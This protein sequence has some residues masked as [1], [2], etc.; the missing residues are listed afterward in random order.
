MV[1]VVAP[2]DDEPFRLRYGLPATVGIAAVAALLSVATSG[3]N[4]CPVGIC[5]N[6][7]ECVLSTSATSGGN[8]V[9]GGNV[10]CSRCIDPRKF[11]ITRHILQINV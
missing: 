10:W 3:G 2:D 5:G 9:S 8:C 6:V 7:R 1:D 11:A 4:V